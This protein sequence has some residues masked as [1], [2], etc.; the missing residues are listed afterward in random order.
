VVVRLGLKAACNA[1]H[2]PGYGQCLAAV[3]TPE[4]AA[5]IT[6]LY[7]VPVPPA[8]RNDLVAIFLTSL[9]GLNQP[10]NVQASEMLRLNMGI[11]PTAALGKGNRMGVLGGDNAGFPNGR[12]LE[13]D[14]VD[15]AIQ[16]VAGATPFTPDF[17]KAP[18]NLLGDGVN[19]SAQSFNQ[20][21]P[22]LSQ[23][24]QGFQRAGGTATSPTGAP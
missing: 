1:T 15:I 6:A 2:P 21:F 3:P 14:V 18:N 22:Y 10:A 23:P 5:L 7:D 24:Y 16:A 11:A 19:Q 17:N 9:P 12:R 4:L 13:D 20:G 8:P